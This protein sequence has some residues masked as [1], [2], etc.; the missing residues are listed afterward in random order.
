MRI[1]VL[2]LYETQMDLASVECFYEEHFK[3]EVNKETSVD[4]CH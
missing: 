2:W 1:G 4:E 3:W